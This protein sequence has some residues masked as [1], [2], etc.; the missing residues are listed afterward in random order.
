MSMSFSISSKLIS[1]GSDESVAHPDDGMR[2]EVLHPP[3]PCR[4]NSHLCRYI[5]IVHEPFQHTLLNDNPRWLERL[6]SHTFIGTPTSL[7]TKRRQ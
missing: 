7:Q 6:R 3:A 4:H 1:S 5:K 2:P